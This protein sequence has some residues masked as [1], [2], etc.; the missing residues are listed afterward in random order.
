M[1]YRYPLV[2]ACLCLTFGATAKAQSIDADA[3]SAR[4]AIAPGYPPQRGYPLPQAGYGYSPPGYGA[5]APAPSRAGAAG[6]DASL[7]QGTHLLISVFP[8]FGYAHTWMTLSSPRLLGTTGNGSI[9]TSTSTDRV[10]FL[11]NSNSASLNPALAFDVALPSGI[12]VGGSFSYGWKGGDQT[13]TFSTGRT[14]TTTTQSVPSVTSFGIG[15]RGG[16]LHMFSEVLGIWVNLGGSYQLQ[17]ETQSSSGAFGGQTQ[18]ETSASGFFLDS[19]VALILSPVRHFAF[20]FG[21]GGSLMASGS[22]T[23]KSGGTTNV[24]ADV[25]GG[26]LGLAVGLLGYL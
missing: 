3:P 4:P 18:S 24:E 14:S 15:A 5:Q 13:V 26:V 9:S 2:A 1:Y 12:T 8:L 21:A 20:L 17:R 11:G 25:S 16:Y 7:G 22:M 10:A 19:N 23:E 6:A